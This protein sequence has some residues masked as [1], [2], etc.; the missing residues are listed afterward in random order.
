MMHSLLFTVSAYDV[1]LSASCFTCKRKKKQFNSF[2]EKKN[3]F[4]LYDN[5][6]RVELFLCKKKFCEEVP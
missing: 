3:F 6:L 5:F 4:V 2:P 1:K